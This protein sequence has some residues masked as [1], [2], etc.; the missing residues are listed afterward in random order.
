LQQ[1]HLQEDEEIDD[2]EPQTESQGPTAGAEGPQFQEDNEEDDSAAGQ[3][4]DSVSWQTSAHSHSLAGPQAH[5]EQAHSGQTS[6]LADEDSEDDDGLNGQINGQQQQT[7]APAYETPTSALLPQTQGPRKAVR[8][9]T[10]PRQL[11]Q[12]SSLET[13]FGQRLSSPAQYE[14][15]LLTSLGP[16]QVPQSYSNGGQTQD[17][18]STSQ[19][20]YPENNVYDS[21]PNYYGSLKQA[22]QPEMFYVPADSVKYMVPNLEDSFFNNE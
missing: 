7:Q 2:Q 9:V 19:V 5:S 11:T 17:Y 16:Q 8:F 15:P 1:P 10:R 6:G 18:L 21:Q 22:S 4:L 12:S 13:G 14:G 20:H 3:N